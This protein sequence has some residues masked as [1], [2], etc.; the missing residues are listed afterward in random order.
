MFWLTDSRDRARTGKRI[1]CKYPED[2]IDRID[3][4]LSPM[5]E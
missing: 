4:M 5:V 1:V 2:L 3:V